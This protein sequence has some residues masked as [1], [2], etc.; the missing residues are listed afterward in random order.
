MAVRIHS[1][2]FLATSHRGSVS[3]SL[4]RNI[5]KLSGAHISKSYVDNLVL[6]SDAISTINDQFGH[7][8][9]DV[10]LWSFFEIVETP[11]GLVIEKGS[12]I[13]GL[14]GERVQLLNADYRHVCKFDGP[15]DSNYCTLR[16]ALGAAISSID[17]TWF[18]TQREEFQSDMKS[19]SKRFI[20]MAN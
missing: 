16:N 5:W 11:L 7:I 3:A 12:A 6:N 19:I 17:H 1:I 4:L 15:S 8:H 14:P 18:S 13:L 10:Q 20:R 2:F 9:Q